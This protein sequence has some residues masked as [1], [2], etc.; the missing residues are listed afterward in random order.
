MDPVQKPAYLSKTVLKAVI[1]S[2]AAM[3][4]AVRDFVASNPESVLW[5]LSAVDVVLRFATKGK[6]T[7]W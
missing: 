2:L 5:A 3:V 1:V 6:I 4:P 7:L